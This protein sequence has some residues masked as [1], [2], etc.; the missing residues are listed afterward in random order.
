MKRV[1]EVKA[2]KAVLTSKRYDMLN[3][4]FNESMVKRTRWYQFRKTNGYK[5]LTKEYDQSVRVVPK[6]KY[7]SILSGK[8]YDGLRVL[9]VQKIM[10]VRF[11]EVADKASLNTNPI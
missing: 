1:D 11:S 3:K 2:K 6:D 9:D 5:Q 8:T 10:N 4:V 7:Q